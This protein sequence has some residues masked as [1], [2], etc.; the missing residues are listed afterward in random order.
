[1][2]TSQRTGQSGLKV[3]TLCLGTMTFGEA[4][5]KSFMHKVGADEETSFA[6][7]ERAVEA[8]VNF[9]DT[10]NV[11]GQDGLAERV[12]GKWL[13]TSRI[14]DSLIIASKFRFRVGDGPN[15]TG[16]SRRHI[17]AACDASLR[18][19]RTDRL[20]LYQIHMQD[21][22][23]P[24]EE[25]L[26]ALDDLVTQGKVMYIG[27]SNYTAARLVDAAWTSRHFD[28]GRYTSFQANYSLMTRDLEREHVSVCKRYGP[29]GLLPYS[30]LGAGFLSGKFQRNQP[31]EPGTRLEKF[32]ERYASFDNDRGWNI[33]D[34]VR[35][36]A[37][38]L[39]TTPSA[40]ALAWL[41]TRPYVTSVIFGARSIEQLNENLAAAEL[42]LP[43][44]WVE[45]LDQASS[46]EMGY[47]Y[48]WMKR[49]LGDW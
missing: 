20:D 43:P 26:R 18:R 10:A 48:D 24:E 8:G 16:A 31:P 21:M 9:I 15:D 41:L 45:K 33:M 6:I 42:T 25:T 49:Q 13:S 44:A 34:T 47:P 14:R 12:L 30:P 5:E 40:V 2:K 39:E 46:F 38:E 29:P 36:A 37:T 27:A 17:M 32:K 7:L 35:A 3:T 4:D 28:L 11:Y 19:L 1:M 22:E 23:T